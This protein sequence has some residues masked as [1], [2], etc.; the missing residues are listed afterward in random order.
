MVDVHQ[1][2]CLTLMD[3]VLKAGFVIVR[4]SVA[5]HG[6]PGHNGLIYILHGR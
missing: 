1:E 5:Q 6:Q 2:L 3:G 4:D